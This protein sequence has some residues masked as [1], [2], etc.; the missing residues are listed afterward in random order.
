MTGTLQSAGRTPVRRWFVDRGYA[1]RKGVNVDVEA[2]RD[3]M[4]K[5]VVEVKGDQ[6]N[7]SGSRTG[8]INGGALRNTFFMGLGQLLIART[9]HSDI[10]ISLALTKMFESLVDKYSDVLRNHG[11]SVIWVSVDC[12]RTDDLADRS[13]RLRSNPTE[14][15][16]REAVLSQG[17]PDGMFDCGVARFCVLHG[18]LNWVKVEGRVDAEITSFARLCEYL[19]IAVGGDSAAR[20]LNRHSERRQDA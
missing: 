12:V 1:V 20:V 19:G 4:L 5:H 3:D 8:Q 18:R 9:R 10:P 6:F 15:S 14:S 7:Q 2:Y 17:H 16:S 11:V 13:P